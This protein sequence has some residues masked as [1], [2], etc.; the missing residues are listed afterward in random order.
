M[1]T[2]YTTQLRDQ[3]DR[4]ELRRRMQERNLRDADL[5]RHLRISRSRLS[6]WMGAR[7]AFPMGAVQQTAALLGC[8]VDSLLRRDSLVNLS[9]NA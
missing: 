6:N 2:L 1:D 3:V 5:A 4:E 9:R 8:S 7:H